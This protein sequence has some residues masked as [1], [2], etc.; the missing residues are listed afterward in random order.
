MN[1]APPPDRYIE[2]A[3]VHGSSAWLLGRIL[4]SPGV[5]TVLRNPPGWVD[6]AELA[7]T[8]AAIHQPPS[9]TGVD[10]TPGVMSG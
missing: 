2:G 8:V 3:L 6:R 4:A 5:A 10:D 1:G 7:A 9:F